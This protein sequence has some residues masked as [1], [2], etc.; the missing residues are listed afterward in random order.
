MDPKK[1]L[2]FSTVLS[3][4]SESLFFNY[5]IDWKLFYLII[6]SNYFII[7][8]IKELK[9]SKIFLIGWVTALVHAVFCY[10]IIQIPPNYFLS[11]LLGI[12]VISTYFYNFIPLFSIDEITKIYTK[13]TVWVAII[14]FVF[15]FFKINYYDG[16]LNS[17][18]KEPA[19]YAAVVLPACF[20]LFKTKKIIPFLIVFVSLMLS[21]SSL[22]Y[23]GI[24]FLIIIPLVNFRRILL[25]ILI[26]PILLLTFN[27][28]Y[29][30]YDFF[31]M[32]V[33][34]TYENVKA[35]KT[36]K[37]QEYVNLTSYAWLVNANIAIQNSEKHPLGSGIGSHYYMFNNRYLEN[38]RVPEYLRKQ[39]LQNVNSSDAASLFLR[40][41]SEFGVI[42]VL[43]ILYLLRKSFAVY[44][45]DLYLAQGIFVYFLLKLIR[46][47]NYFTPELYFFIWL[48]Y[49]NL[50]EIK[51]K[52]ENNNNFIA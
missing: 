43:L 7:F 14:G 12:F 6:L 42:G 11:Q 2:L 33:D 23:I 28:L 52:D 5:I 29:E 40:M 41:L 50:K 37:F 19:H 20:Y 45:F 39:D 49:F 30:T 25:S 26:I 24:A 13:I 27:Y 48:L 8:Q 46:E 38:I 44:A 47:G 31:K 16:R 3:I 34:D 32:R 4:F 17:I 10:S 35:V 18:F 1:Y 21:Q 9:I 36:G 51:K 22:A 15:L